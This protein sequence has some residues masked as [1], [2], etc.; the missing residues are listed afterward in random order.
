MPPAPVEVDHIPNRAEPDPIDDVTERA[1]ADHAQGNPLKVAFRAPD[2]YEEDQRDGCR[3]RDEH[4][5][6][7]FRG[8]A[9]GDAGIHGGRDGGARRDVAHTAPSHTVER[10]RLPALLPPTGPPRTQPQNPTA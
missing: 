2:Q 3:N 4:D 8:A 7:R 6:L 5:G 9:E 1:A 10:G